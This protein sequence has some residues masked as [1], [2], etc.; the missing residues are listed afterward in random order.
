MTARKGVLIGV[1]VLALVLTPVH[2]A[3][4]A[5]GPGESAARSPEPA[6]T[7]ASPAPGAGDIARVGTA[8]P[9]PA[10]GASLPERTTDSDVSAGTTDSNV[11]TGTSTGAP[12]DGASHGVGTIRVDRR[13]FLTPA[14]DRNVTVETTVTLPEDVVG[15]LPARFVEDFQ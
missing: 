14:D 8:A 3:S 6:V 1:V 11:S 15:R 13:L 4:V 7:D 10:D 9:A 5:T 2:G 12:S